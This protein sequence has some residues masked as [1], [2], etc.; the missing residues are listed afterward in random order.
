MNQVKNLLKKN[1]FVFCGA[2]RYKER[3]TSDSTS[4]NL[5]GYFKT[6]FINLTKVTGL[7]NKNPLTNK[8]ARFIPKISWQAFFKM[9]NKIKFQPGQHFVLDQNAAKTI[10]ENKI[11]TYIIGRNLKTLKAV[12][13]GKKFKGTIIAG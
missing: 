11:K 10:M 5:A 4:A 3:Q 12:L 13:N 1:D 6:D 2:L 9:A 8:D 7:Y